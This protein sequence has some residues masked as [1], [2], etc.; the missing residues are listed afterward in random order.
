MS[1]YWRVV[2]TNL[3]GDRNILE[4]FPTKELARTYKATL[5]ALRDF[6]LMTEN[7]PSMALGDATWKELWVEPDSTEDTPNE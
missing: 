5:M 6:Y 4:E 7:I 2:R 1:N 3:D